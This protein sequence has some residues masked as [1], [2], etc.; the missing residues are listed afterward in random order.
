MDELGT[1]VQRDAGRV[2]RVDAADEAVILL[3]RRGLHQPL[4][5]R[6]TDAA[7]AVVT[8]HVQRVLD[9]VLV[10]GAIAERT[11]AAEPDERA[12]VVVSAD[13][14]VVARLPGREPGRDRLRRP[15]TVVVAG[16]R[17]QDRL[18]Q[19]LQYRPRIA[20]GVARAVPH[21]SRAAQPA[22]ISSD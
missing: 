12:V 20:R 16:G 11:V 5:Q 6:V 8:V 7:T 13:D 14:R 2:A 15:G 9:A 3:R 18:V 21:A 10:R 1:H 19:D 4:Q 22:G 17:V